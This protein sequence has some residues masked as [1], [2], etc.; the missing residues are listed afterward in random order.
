MVFQISTTVTTV[1]MKK[2]A[3]EANIVVIEMSKFTPIDYIRLTG[4]NTS[5]L[6]QFLV[7]LW[8]HVHVSH[9]LW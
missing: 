5:C 8:T 4:Q 3:M 7:L 9:L 2:H 1:G 6:V